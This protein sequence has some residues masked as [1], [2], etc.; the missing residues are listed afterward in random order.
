MKTSIKRG[1]KYGMVFMAVSAVMGFLYGLFGGL[2]LQP[3]LVAFTC[4][5]VFAA[6]F[7]ILSLI[8]LV[9]ALL[10]KLAGVSISKYLIFLGIS[11][12]FVLVYLPFFILIKMLPY[13]LY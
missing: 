6:I 11:I 8:A 9:P 1:L 10:M 3:A 7:F 12:G 2:F 5:G 13:T 4:V